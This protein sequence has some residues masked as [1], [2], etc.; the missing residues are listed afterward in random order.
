MVRT[1]LAGVES[2]D[3]PLWV[4]RASKVYVPGKRVAVVNV[5]ASL[6]ESKLPSLGVAAFQLPRLILYS[7]FAILLIVIEFPLHGYGF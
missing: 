5:N 1:S 7:T 4:A 2:A 6:V 3:P